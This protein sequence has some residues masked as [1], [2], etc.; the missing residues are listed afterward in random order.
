MAHEQQSYF[1]ERLFSL[2]VHMF[3]T[4]LLCVNR[5]QV[6]RLF[7]ARIEF[8]L[9]KVEVLFPREALDRLALRP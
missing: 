6:S 5:N 1:V 2:L 7:N 8:E 4:M 9:I 3:Q